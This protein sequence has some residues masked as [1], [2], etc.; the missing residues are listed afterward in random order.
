M[1]TSHQEKLNKINTAIDSEKISIEKSKEK[2]KRL[3]Q[4]KKKTEE[5]IVKEMHAEL[6]NY[7]TDFGINSVNDFQK[8][9][10][11]YTESDNQK[12]QNT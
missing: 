1:K 10:N 11:E 3:R 9:L 7:L 12:D 4:Q 2:I 6:F 5:A 8:F